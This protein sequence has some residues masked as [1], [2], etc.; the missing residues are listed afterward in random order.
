MPEQL[1][2]D[3]TLNSWKKRGK[4][5]EMVTELKGSQFAQKISNSHAASG[6]YIKRY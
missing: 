4:T 6:I 2:T 3:M 1:K 5:Q